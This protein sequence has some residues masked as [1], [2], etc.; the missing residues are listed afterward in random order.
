MT[1]ED[2]ILNKQN[3]TSK[4]RLAIEEKGFKIGDMIKVG[5]KLIKIVGITPSYYL[6]LENKKAGFDPVYMAKYKPE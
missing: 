1:N 3:D 2:Q 5:S 4:R 6:L